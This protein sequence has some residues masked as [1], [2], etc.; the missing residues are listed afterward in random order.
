MSK[1]HFILSRQDQQKVEYIGR[2]RSPVER[3][4]DPGS[5]E[6]ILIDILCFDICTFLR[7]GWTVVLREDL[8]MAKGRF[9]PS[10]DWAGRFVA[11]VVAAKMEGRLIL[12]RTSGLKTPPFR[13]A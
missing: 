9:P 3:L 5:Y 11:R 2:I 4:E 6:P 8:E 7:S 12:I 1:L 10:P 13:A